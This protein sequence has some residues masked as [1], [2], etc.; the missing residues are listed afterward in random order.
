LKR[1]DELLIHRLQQGE[2]RGACAPAPLPMTHRSSE[3]ASTQLRFA[4]LDTR[5]W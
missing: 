4:Y 5:I 1:L 3:D 2:P